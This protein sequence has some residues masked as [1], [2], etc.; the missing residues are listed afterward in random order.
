MYQGSWP[1]NS[2]VTNARGTAKGIICS[3]LIFQNNILNISLT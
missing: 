1:N 3:T 2:E